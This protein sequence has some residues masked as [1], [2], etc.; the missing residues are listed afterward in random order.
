MTWNDIKERI[1]KKSGYEISTRIILIP[2]GKPRT[3]GT[4]KEKGL[5]SLVN[6]GFTSLG[7]FIAP[8]IPESVFLRNCD[9]IEITP[10]QLEVAKLSLEYI[11]NILYNDAETIDNNNEQR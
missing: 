4:Q 7:Y 3:V 6:E 5:W 10:S 11:Y 2:Y 1:K 8:E 9:T